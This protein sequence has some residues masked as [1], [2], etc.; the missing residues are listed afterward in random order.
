MEIAIKWRDKGDKWQEF[1]SMDILRLSRNHSIDLFSRNIPVVIRQGD[2]VVSNDSATR[3]QY[4]KIAA[5][6]GLTVYDLAKLE[7]SDD[8]LSTVGF[9]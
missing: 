2:N 1:D 3:Q 7:R 4:H 9:V 8:I 6:D 5:R